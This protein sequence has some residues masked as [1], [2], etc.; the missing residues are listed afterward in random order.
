MYKKIILILIIIS[1]VWIWKDYKKI[2]TG[3]VNQSSITYSYDNLN[4][5]FIKK[6]HVLINSTYENFLYNN[7]DKHKDYWKIEDKSKR[8]NLPKFKILK[9]SENFTETITDLKNTGINWYRSHGN[10]SSNRFSSLK[11]NK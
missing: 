9:S 8:D 3:F 5:S 1:F 10:N 4:S 11:K 7:I 6:V 2:D